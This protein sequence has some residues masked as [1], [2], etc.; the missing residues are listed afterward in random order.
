[1]SEAGQLVM[2]LLDDCR[3]AV[4][5]A[6]V[7]RI[8]PLVDITRLPQAPDIVRGVINV[9]GRVI[10]VIDIRRRFRL[11]ERE[12]SLNDQIILAQ[13]GR[14][15]VAL[16]VDAALGVIDA[17]A[18]MIAQI[19]EILPGL[20]HV[21]GLVKRADGLILIHDLDTFLSLEEAEKLEGALAQTTGTS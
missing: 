14:H 12:S 17:P 19:D 6:A 13:A 10:P 18:T 21:A 5:L 7:R 8:V 20:E 1:M 4:R 9:E 16:I 11:P 3:Y 2:F 15:A